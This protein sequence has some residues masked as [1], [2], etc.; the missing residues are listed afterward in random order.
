MITLPELPYAENALE[1][2][3]SAETMQTHHGKHHKKYVD[4]LNSLIENNEMVDFTLEQIIKATSGGENADQKKIFNNAAQCWNHAFFWSC[5]T[6]DGG[7]EPGEILN[8]LIIRDFG[9]YDA[10]AKK[11]VEAGTGHFGSGWVW[12][13]SN[14]DALEIITTHDADLPLASGKHA[15]IT[16]DLWE[17]AYYLDYKNDR[18]KFLATFLS[19]LANWDFAETNMVHVPKSLTAEMAD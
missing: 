3:V 7:G 5:M 18:P 19:N 11:F 4:T 2:H 16:C 1:P 10:F 15:L 17:H 9:G 12:L 14:K 13:V 8:D 6:P